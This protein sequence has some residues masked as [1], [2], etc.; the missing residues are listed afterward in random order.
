M[1]GD[2]VAFLTARLDEDEAAAAEAGEDSGP[3]WRWQPEELPGMVVASGSGEIVVYDEGRPT[4]AGG[5]HIARYDPAR[6]LAGVAAKRAILAAYERQFTERKS[7][8]GDLAASGALLA[9]HGAVKALAAVYSGH[10]DYDP[11]WAIRP[12]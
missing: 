3:E 1:S 12:S 5:A 11:K 7:H 4:G 2:L 10:P 9:L 8:P 6:V